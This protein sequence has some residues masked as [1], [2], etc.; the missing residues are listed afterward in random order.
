MLANARHKC[1]PL[2][3]VRAVTMVAP[4][5]Q[6]EARDISSDADAREVMGVWSRGGEECT[7]RAVG[8]A[9]YGEVRSSPSPL[10]V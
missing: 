3:H 5:Q 1:S 7:A 2:G 9:S 6:L 4:P 10:K 8:R